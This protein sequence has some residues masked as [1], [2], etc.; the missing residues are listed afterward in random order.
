MFLRIETANRDGVKIHKIAIEAVDKANG[1]KYALMTKSA[2]DMHKKYTDAK[3][4]NV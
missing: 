1:N 2:Y 4:R 3:I